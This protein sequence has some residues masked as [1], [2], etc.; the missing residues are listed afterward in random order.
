MSDSRDPVEARADSGRDLY[1]VSTWEPRSLLDSLSVFVYSAGVSGLRL[2][3]VVLALA[4][5]ASQFVLGG[6][7]AVTDPIVGTFTLLSAVPALGLAAYVWY[8]DVTS[9]EPLELLVGTFALGVLFAGFAGVVNTVV[10][11]S[12]ESLGLM[13][14]GTQILYFFL[15][16]GPVEETVKLLAVRLYAY[17]TSKFDAVVDGAVYGAMAGLGFATI[18]NAI[19]IAGQ[20]QGIADTFNLVLAGSGITAVRALAGPGHVIY[21]AFAGYYLGLAKFNPDRAGPIVVKGLI[22]ATVVHAL[23]NT[24]SGYLPGVVA[25]ITGIP[26]FVA[27]FGF[28]LVYDGVFGLLLIRKISRYR[29]AY[30]EATDEAPDD[31]PAELTEFDG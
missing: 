9:S 10:S 15:V 2:L 3:V 6:L 23:Y 14:W 7:G 22:I 30:R 20:T 16:V 28:I 31:E 21:S 5:L 29:R 12:L 17:R 18:E 13:F 27:F 1:E 19:Y 11:V 25:D 8:A 24:L 4:I 26:W